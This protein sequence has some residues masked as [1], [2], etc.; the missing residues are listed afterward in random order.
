MKRP[1]ACLS[2]KPPSSSRI[3][4][5]DPWSDSA[6]VHS[7]PPTTCSLSL[8]A[9]QSKNS[10]SSSPKELKRTKICCSDLTGLQITVWFGALNISATTESGR[11]INSVDFLFIHP[12]FDRASLANDIAVLHLQ[13]RV[14]PAPF[15]SPI[16]MAPPADV[17]ETYQGETLRTCGWGAR[18][19]LGVLTE[20]SDILQFADNVGENITVCENYYATTP[21]FIIDETKICLS[22]TGARGPC[23]NDEGA[24]L[25]FQQDNT[26]TL[27]GLFALGNYT[28]CIRSA[29]VV[30][31]RVASHWDFITD[32]TGL[33]PS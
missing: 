11:E 24:P 28:N 2:T 3:G 18:M 31:T 6:T 30:Y 9:F 20:F 32:V 26:D 13:E 12:E 23:K 7:S 4:L 21:E 14:A 25:S 10:F 1:K 33:T 8:I 27:V 17:N 22:T 5:T 16:R 29:P 19:D 15:V